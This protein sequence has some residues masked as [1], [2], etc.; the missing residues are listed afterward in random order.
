MSVQIGGKL[1]YTVSTNY[2]RL[3][4]LASAGERI[5]CFVDMSWP[6]SSQTIYRDIA[7]TRRNEYYVEIGCR[8]TCY[9]EARPEEKELFIKRCRQ[10]HVEFIDPEAQAIR[11]AELA[12][13]RDRLR[14]ALKKIVTLS[15]PDRVCSNCKHYQELGNTDWCGW[16]H[17][18][19]EDASSQ[20]CG[21]F[22]VAGFIVSETHTIAQEALKGAVAKN[23]TVEWRI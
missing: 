21:K 23:A 16:N 10:N 5:V 22:E 8:G 20:E 2:E 7:K 6:D 12:A 15:T 13:E 18:P 17:K 14:E 9:L 3:W 4:E 19:L 1:N 11:I